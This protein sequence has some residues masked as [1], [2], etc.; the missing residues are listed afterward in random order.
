M[1]LNENLTN[2]VENPT[3]ASE[4]ELYGLQYIGE[5]VILRCTK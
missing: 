5:Y 4:R 2:N 3:N 1:Q